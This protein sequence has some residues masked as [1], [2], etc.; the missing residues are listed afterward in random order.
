MYVNKQRYYKKHHFKPSLVP[1]SQFIICHSGIHRLK[2]E[3][4]QKTI[5]L[6]KKETKEL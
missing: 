1:W 4:D 3:T 2:G 5:G 6:G